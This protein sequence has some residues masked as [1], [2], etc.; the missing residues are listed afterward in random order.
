MNMADFE[1]KTDEYGTTI[2]KLIRVKEVGGG[3]VRL[4]GHIMLSIKHYKESDTEMMIVRLISL[5]GNTITRAS[6]SNVTASEKLSLNK[7]AATVNHRTNSVDFGPVQGGYI[8]ESLR[9]RGIGSF[10]FNELISWLKANFEDYAVNPF[11]FLSPENATPDDIDRRNRFLESFGFTLGFTDVTQKSGTMKAK[12]V[13]VLKERYNAEKI[14]EL[15][16]EQFVFN[17]INEKAS[18]EKSYGDLKTE[19]AARGEELLA[20]IPKSEIIKYTIIGCVLVLFIM[21]LLMV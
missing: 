13:S 1:Q 12:K 19:Y 15:D 4:F 6:L 16:I 21:V 10:G 2:L 8:E 5:A 20:G 9:G 3:S 18:L 14:E 11:E 7:F 17:L